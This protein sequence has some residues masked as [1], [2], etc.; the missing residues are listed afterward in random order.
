MEPEFWHTRWHR[1]ETGFH[2][3]EHNPYLK[4][5]WPSLGVPPGGHILVPLCGK[6]LDMRYLRDAGFKVS[7]VE[8]SSLACRAFFEEMGVTPSHHQDGTFQV[9]ESEG[10]R[11][12]CGDFFSLRK[13]V[14]GP[15]DGIYDRAALIALPLTQRIHY[16]RKIAELSQ[17]QT[18]GLLI[19]LTYTDGQKKGPPF[20][21]PVDEVE[22]LYQDTFELSLRQQDDVID[23]DP[24]Y[25][26]RWGVTS[27][28]TS[29]HALLPRAS[30]QP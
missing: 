17:P 14:L 21:V 16:A 15:V 11:L 18:R 25:R 3:T 6:T 8:V 20:S 2:A 19:S 30:T 26:E 13:E 29:V 1:G 27:L 4:A 5:Y 7:G 22:T 9:F 23:S 24:R 28:V 10:V 12:L